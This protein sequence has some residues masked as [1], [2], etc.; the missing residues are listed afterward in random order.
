MRGIP[1]CILDL[2]D[3][4][5]PRFALVDGVVAMEG[6]GPIN[7]TAKEMGFYVIG[8]DLAAV[9]ATCARTMGFDPYELDYIKIAGEVVGN[10]N[11]DAITVLGLDIERVKQKF[12]RPVTFKNKK[13]MEQSANQAS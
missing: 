5:K 9:D 8:D 1:Q 4:I 3:L 11:A 13:L 6:D 10:V 2:Q 7:G 12:E